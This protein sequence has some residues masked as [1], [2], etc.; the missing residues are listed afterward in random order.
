MSLQNKWS[1]ALSFALRSGTLL[2][3]SSRYRWGLFFVFAIGFRFLF[4]FGLGAWV[5]RLRLD[6][7]IFGCLL[8]RGGLVFGL[9]HL[10]LLFLWF[11]LG[12]AFYF[13]FDG[14]CQIVHQLLE[15]YLVLTRAVELFVL[16]LDMLG[17]GSL[18][19]IALMAILS[20]TWE[21]SSDFIREPAFAAD[22][23]IKLCLFS[24][25]DVELTLRWL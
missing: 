16:E 25:H 13:L 1:F 14:D 6:L 15:Q 20:R 12:F 11:L 2:C 4:R 8:F 23:I 19:S 22:S 17:Q 10:Y 21:V 18:R 3:W 9:L 24:L 7:V 5:G